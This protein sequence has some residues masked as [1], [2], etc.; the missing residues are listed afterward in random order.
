MKYLISSFLLLFLFSCKSEKDEPV[1]E[2]YSY[3]CANPPVQKDFSPGKIYMPNIFTPNGDG[4]NDR[5]FVHIDD[6]IEEVEI[7]R[8]S[9][10]EEN[11]VFE[12]LNFLPFDMI[13]ETSWTSTNTKGSFEYFVQVRNI[14]GEVFDFTGDL[15]VFL[16]DEDDIPD[17]GDNYL[18][19]GFS[20]QN[21]P[22]EGVFDPTQ[23]TLENFCF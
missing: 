2:D 18:N 11:T 22:G 1:V 6:G 21:V 19:C 14:E 10:E 23:P 16:C 7:F 4:I 3:C 5:F 8:I 9:D 17:L 15:C 12:V 20:V 13:D